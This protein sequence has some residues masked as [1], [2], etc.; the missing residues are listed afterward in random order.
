MQTILDVSIMPEK[1]HTVACFDYTV[2]VDLASVSS[3]RAGSISW[4]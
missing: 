1:V 2:L 3:L 4:A